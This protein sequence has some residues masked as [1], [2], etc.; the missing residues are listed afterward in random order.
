VPY[1]APPLDTRIPVVATIHDLIPLVLPEYRGSLG[2]RAYMRL[3]ALGAQRARLVL[4]DSQA[5]ARDIAERLRIS[6][7]QLRVVYLAASEIYRPVPRNEQEACLRR[8]GVHRPYLLYLGGFDVRKNVSG[9]MRAFR[10]VEPQ[11]RG[12]RLVIAGRP[13]DRHSAFSPHPERVARQ[14]GLAERIHFTGHVAEEDKPALYSGALGFLFPSF[15]EG[16]GL[17]VLEALSCGTPAI[18]G[19]GS[20][21]EEIAGPG[22]IPIAPG[23]DRALADAMQELVDNEGL[24]QQLAENG[25]AH[26]ASFSWTRTAEQTREAYREALAMGQSS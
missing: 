15:Y 4:T 2:V 11:L 10:L 1:F 13:P 12:V 23:D 19:E 6:L 24:R 7:K 3:V 16:F 8:L 18:Y 17:P 20:S 21:L 14:L 5:S 26:A 9:I 25:L 22:G